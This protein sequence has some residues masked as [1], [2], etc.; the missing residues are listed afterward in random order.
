MDEFLKFLGERPDPDGPWDFDDSAAIDSPK[1]AL[2]LGI[3]S[4]LAYSGEDDM[5]TYLTDHGF[6]GGFRF[7]S[8]DN[9]FGFVARL[10]DSAT[11]PIFIAYRGTEPTMLAEVA[12]DVDYAQVELNGLIGKVHGGFGRAFSSLKSQTEQA[13]GDFPGGNHYFTGHSLGGAIAVLAAAAFRDKATAVITFGQPRVGDTRFAEAYNQELGAVT[14]RYVNN[15]DIIPHVPPDKLP[16]PFPSLAGIPP[17][18]G[19]I[20]AGVERG[21]RSLLTGESFAHVGQ[22][23][24]FI[25]G[26][27]LADAITGQT[28]SED[29][30]DFEKHD[31]I[32]F[33]RPNFL[34]P[35][36]AFEEGAN[37]VRNEYRGFPDHDP[38][39][40]YLPRLQQLAKAEV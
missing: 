33:P 10:T 25:D 12:A 7:L 9:A 36:G 20:L 32:G 28:V 18:F 26:T 11:S 4:L 16:A 19:E 22:L 5:K 30:A 8:G 24:L 40:G 2:A 38:K 1:N 27:P 31:L 17:S 37:I 13:L 3:L 29:P 14:F 6:T 21:V 34:D 35:L 39:H 23:K 15:Y